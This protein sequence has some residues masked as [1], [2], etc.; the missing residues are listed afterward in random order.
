MH[1]ILIDHE[2][3]QPA[4]LAGLDA[5]SAY[6]FVFTGAQQKVGIALIEAVQNLGE[7]GRFIR[8]SGN[9][10][11]AL[12]FH[13]ACY[14]GQWIVRD[15]TA[16]FLIVSNDTGFDP[17]IAHINTSG[18]RI[19]RI[20]LD[21]P[22]KAAAKKLAVKATPQAT[23]KALQA[24]A[25]TATPASE[26]PAAKKEKPVKVIVDPPPASVSAQSPSPP[27][28]ATPSGAAISDADK[29]VKRLL[30]MPKNLPRSEASLRRMVGTWLSKDSKRLDS[31]L[32]VLKQ[33]GIIALNGT[34][35]GYQLPKA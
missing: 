35:L 8:I 25:N 27:P 20:N 18:A 16:T 24:P 28:S 4:D 22:T 17:L 5:D 11:N 30:D 26:K 15:P 34:R 32:K 29:V 2:N 12:D 7:R 6:V 31:V 1:Y 21:P 19:K 23:D 10:P 14:L 33:R 13:I 9:G 3:V